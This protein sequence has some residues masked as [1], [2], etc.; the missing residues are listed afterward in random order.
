MPQMIDNIAGLTAFPV[1]PRQQFTAL[2]GGFRRG[3]ISCTIVSTNLAGLGMDEVCRY[4]LYGL[5]LPYCDEA[6]CL[7]GAASSRPSAPPPKHVSAAA[8]FPEAVI[9][10][11]AAG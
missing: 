6:V 11:S 7:A 1:F 8:P 2:L 4:A 10:D 5:G 3:A 9:A